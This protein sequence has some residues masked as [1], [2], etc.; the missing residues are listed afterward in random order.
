MANEDREEELRILE[1][2][3]FSRTSVVQAGPPTQMISKS[4][5]FN[6][7]TDNQRHTDTTTCYMKL[8]SISLNV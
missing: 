8:R 6:D 2:N 5:K 3:L 4:Q 1:V 7:D